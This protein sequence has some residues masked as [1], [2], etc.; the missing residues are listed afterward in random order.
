MSKLTSSVHWEGCIG[1]YL[2]DAALYFKNSLIGSC[3]QV[4]V[5]TIQSYILADTG[6]QL[7]CCLSC[8]DLL[9]RPGCVAHL[10]GQYVR[11]TDAVNAGHM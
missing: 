7:A 2:T 5:A 3:P 6:L 11:A 8:L 9:L 4:N 10:K 1:E